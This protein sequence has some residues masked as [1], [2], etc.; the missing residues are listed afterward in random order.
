MM[1]RLLWLAVALS[2]LAVPLAFARA[3][4]GPRPGTAGPPV[5]VVCT[6]EN[7]AYAGACVESTT[8]SAKETPAAAC[9]PI[10]EC[11]NNPMCVKTYCQATSIRQGWT[12]KSAR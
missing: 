4:S 7:P 3:G 12:L 1:T 6:F 5:K 2:T 8:R 9:Q 11:L 10:L